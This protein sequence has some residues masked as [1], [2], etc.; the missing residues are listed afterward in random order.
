MSRQG[1][2]GRVDSLAIV[3]VPG[4]A[5]VL[6]ACSLALTRGAAAQNLEQYDYENLGLRALGVEVVYADA[7][8]AEGAVGFGIRA[9]LGFLGPYVRVVP[10]FAHWKADIE[11]DAV[12]RFEMNLEQLC[13]LEGCDISLGSL[14]R[15]FWLLGLDLQWT[16][17]E[18]VIAP[19]FGLGIDAYL[20]DDSGDAIKGT[21]LDDAVVTAGLSGVAGLEW[22]IRD[23]LRLYADFRGTLITSASSLAGY[24]GLAYRF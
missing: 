11:S 10:R 24:V 23:H 19:Y 16:P 13:D 2:G 3:R 18:A 7:K 12:A 1:A 5:L 22:E 14:R 20:L 21:F 4:T 9:D 6:M 17:P 15:N 8:D